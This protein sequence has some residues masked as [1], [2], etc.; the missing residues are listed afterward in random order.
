M[1]NQG[2]VEKLNTDFDIVD[3]FNFNELDIECTWTGTSSGDHSFS[4]PNTSS[5]SSLDDEQ[6]AIVKKLRATKFLARFTGENRDQPQN[7]V[8]ETEFFV[9]SWSLQ[10]NP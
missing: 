7:Y 3:N 10:Q 1:I 5:S 2:Q 9:E 8:D 6:K 4:P